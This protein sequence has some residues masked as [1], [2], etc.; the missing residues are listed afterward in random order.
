MTRRLRSSVRSGAV[1]KFFSQARRQ[2]EEE[3]ARTAERRHALVGPAALWEMKREFQIRFLKSQGLKPSHRLLDVGC[4]TLRG[5]IPLIDYLAPGNYAGCEVRPEALEEGRAELREAGLERKRP[6]LVCAPDF[7]ATAAALAAD[8]PAGGGRFDMMWAYS[9]LIHFSDDV[10][11]D[12]L[13]F[14][15]GQLAE[16]GVFYANVNLG[17][18][19]NGGWQ[20]FPVVWRT[21]DFYSAACGEHGLSV[22]EIGTVKEHGHVSDNILG[23]AQRI[24]KIT[25]A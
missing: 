6:V 12:C 14:A 24:L 3:R 18:R 23:D 1:G 9:V 8:S 13:R 25:R 15:A 21:L 5:G 19:D 22:S 20:G 7:T 2:S 16:S 10:L 17:G 11:H 4:G